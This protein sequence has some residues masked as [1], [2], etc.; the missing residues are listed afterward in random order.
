MNI[1]AVDTSGACACVAILYSGSLLYEASL[2]ASLTHSE[3]LAPMIDAAFSYARL[4][5]ADIDIFAAAAGPGSFT[6]IRIGIAAV[7]AL[8][9]ATGKKATGI[10]TLEGLA[11]NAP[12]HRRVCALIDA[13]NRQVYASFYDTFEGLSPLSQP[14]A[15]SVDTLGTIIGYED[16]SVFVGDGAVAYKT[17]LLNMF[18]GKAIFPPLHVMQ[19]RAASIG[20]AAMLKVERGEL[21]DQD[22]LKPLYLKKTQAEMKYVNCGKS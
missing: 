10:N 17:E 4:R 18:G 16:V 14:A 12:G 13:R 15:V 8:A 1:L 7:Q 6:G 22:G 11:A 20:Y 21:A 5:P 19:Q 9:H 2:N 3:T